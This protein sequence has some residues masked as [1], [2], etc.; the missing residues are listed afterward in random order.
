MRVLCL[1]LWGGW[2]CLPLVD[3]LPGMGADVPCLQEVV[4]TPDAPAPVLTYRDG[5][6]VL[7]QRATLLDD[8]RAA[9][10]DQDAT[11]AP[12]TRR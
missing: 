10:P 9:L 6:H 7:D 12:A 11:F 3:W 8:L 1:N 2:P 4:H 5:D